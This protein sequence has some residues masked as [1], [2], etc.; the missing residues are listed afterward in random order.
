[1]QVGVKIAVDIHLVQQVPVQMPDDRVQIVA[2]G[3]Q[4]GKVG[5]ILA[6]DRVDD[7]DHR[8]AVDQLGGQYTRGGVIRKHARI[9][10]DRVIGGVLGHEARVARLDKVVELLGQPAYELVDHI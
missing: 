1:M 6:A 10:F 8:D 7:V 9:A 5:A 4:V 3:L 2:T